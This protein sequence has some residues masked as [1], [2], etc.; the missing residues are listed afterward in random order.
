MRVGVD[1][2]GTNTDAVLLDGAALVAQAK[3]PTTSDVT[4]GIVAALD[5]LLGAAPPGAAIDGVM[6]GTTH[7]VN[8][9]LERRG[10]APTAVVRLAVPATRLLHPLVD[11]PDDLKEA[12]GGVFY[13]THGGHE[14]DGKQISAL[15]DAEIRAVGRLLKRDGIEA[16]AVCGVFSAVDASHEERAAALLREEAPHLRV[17]L[18][19]QIGRVGIL[20]RENATALNAALSLTAE[21]TIG[22]IREAMA[23]L[24]LDAP[25]YLT[26]NDGTLMQADYAA[27]YPVFTIASGPTNSMRGAAFLSDVRDGIVVDVGGTSTDVGALVHGFPREASVAVSIAG[28]RTN[29]RMPDVVSTGLGGGSIVGAEPLTVGPRSVAYRLTEEALCFGGDVPTATDLAVAG[30]MASVGNAAPGVDPALA[31]RGLRL[32]RQRVEDLIDRMKVA[33]GPVPVVLVGGGNILLP[34]ELEGASEVLRPA[35]AEVANAI[36]AAI[37]QVSGQVEQVFSLDGQDRAQALAAAKRDAV[38]K[39][40]AAGADPATVELV[41]V[42]EIPLTYLPSNA[43]R[44]RAKAAGDLLAA[45]QRAS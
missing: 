12:I 27:N 8:A 15:D 29:F 24:G 11:W 7:F 37:A 13:M 17:S 42:D 45:P 10:L 19:H 32:I 9:L 2:G 20:E 44:V 22:A 3:R 21:R 33:A 30:G 23:R 14:F 39:A 40:V 16:A 38:A 25:L 26:Q 4:S 5:A 43:L 35:H 28:V 31:E 36:G 41:E 18:S 6:L 34:D 1:V